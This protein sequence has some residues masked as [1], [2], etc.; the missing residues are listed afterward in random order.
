MHPTAE[1]HARCCAG[2]GLDYILDEALGG[3]GEE[4]QANP[5][6]GIARTVTSLNRFMKSLSN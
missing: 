1:V 2:D 3:D 6:G 5:F 4:S